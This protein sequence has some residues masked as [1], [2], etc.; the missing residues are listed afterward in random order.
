MIE[1]T[2]SKMQSIPFD[3]FGKVASYLTI[4]ELGIL[5]SSCKTFFEYRNYSQLWD[6]IKQ[7][8]QKKLLKSLQSHLVLGY[9]STCDADLNKQIELARQISKL[10]TLQTVRWR[11]PEYFP[12][13]ETDNDFRLFRMEA[14]TMNTFLDRFL[15]IVGGWSES[16]E[17]EITVLDG[18]L[19][20]ECILSIPTTTSSFP[21]FRYGFSTV[22]YDNDLWVFGG[23]RNG[24]YS[25]DCN[26]KI[27]LNLDFCL[28]FPL[29][30]ISV[31]L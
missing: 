12:V 25:A 3:T 27:N 9:N 22:V 26:G 10:E 17:N 20:P 6:A 11:R 13:K 18:A 30:S 16:S 28:H 31:H 14:H 19:L 7:R 5:T 2:K 23:C 21:R 29:T 24:G 15:I 4:N 1:G 8:G